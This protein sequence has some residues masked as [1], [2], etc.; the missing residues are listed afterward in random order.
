MKYLISIAAGMMLGYY[1]GQ[2]YE[3]DLLIEEKGKL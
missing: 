1:I 2:H 3:V